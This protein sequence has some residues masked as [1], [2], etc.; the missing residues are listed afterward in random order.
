MLPET[1]GW[2]DDFVTSDFDTQFQMMAAFEV[3]RLDY[4][5]DQAPAEPV[6]SVAGLYSEAAPSEPYIM[7]LAT[8][9]TEIAL[10]TT[11][12]A[13]LL[14][15]AGEIV[16]YAG[17]M[18]REEAEE[19]RDLIGD[20][21]NAP[22]AQARIR[23][24]TA[25][26]SGHDFMV[27]S[28]ATVE[29]LTLSLVFA[30]STPL[31]DIRRQGRRLEAALIDAPE[32][33]AEPVAAIST[34][35]AST[36]GSSTPALPDVIEDEAIQRTPLAFVWLLNDP[37]ARLEPAVAQAITSGLRVQLIELLWDIRELH[38]DE[39]FVYLLAHVPGEEPPFH[40]VRDL[41]RRAGEIA[42]AQ[43]AALAPDT[44]WSDSYLVVTPGRPLDI[45]EIQQFISFERM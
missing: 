16:G 39:D 21:W 18:P 7:Q 29:D 6:E 11:A 37:T 4:T 25:P 41:K 43:N 33:S 45:E 35:P 34:P 20:D 42:R 1:G 12:E 10:E 36:L 17:A 30:G 19:L 22:P 26:S 9:L 8:S 5:S 24:V 38:V 23:F 31:R 2:G 15:R 27:Y 28:R 3:A 13:I 32:A 14:V 44:L 40:L